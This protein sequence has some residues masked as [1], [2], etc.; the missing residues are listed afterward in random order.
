MSVET[1]MQQ[2]NNAQQTTPQPQGTRLTTFR[3]VVLSVIIMAAA[4]VIIFTRN[5]QPEWD[6]DLDQYL[7]IDPALIIYEEACRVNTG[8]QKPRGIAIGQ[9]DTLYVAGDNSVRIFDPAP[10]VTP[11]PTERE[12]PGPPRTEIEL[13]SPPQCVAVADD[14]A[15]YVGMIDHVEVYGPDGARRAAWDNFGEKATL[16]SIAFSDG[17]VIVADAGARA[18]L[19]CNRSGIVLARIGEKDKARNVDGIVAPS[20]HLDVATAPDG[21]LRVTNPGRHRVEA[22]TCNGDLEFWWGKQSMTVGGFSG[23]CNPTDIAVLSDGSV[24]TGEKGL[25][26]IKVYEAV[27]GNFV[28]VVAGPEAFREA[29][30]HGI[31]PG[32]VGFDLAA[33]SNDRVYVLDPGTKT[34]RIFTR[35]AKVSDD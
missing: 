22:Y 20:P 26:R 15:I 4:A 2:N 24:V 16:T 21:L 3:S 30:A 1:E 33:D 12:L 17:E 34:V 29:A 6:Y 8:L 11:A 25:A 14:G 28:G 13:T 7:R 27:T 9:D 31:G 35:K 5:E 10:L 19:R 32:F 23:C 18:V